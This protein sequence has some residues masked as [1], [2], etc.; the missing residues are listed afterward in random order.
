M[1]VIQKNFTFF[2]LAR[3]TFTYF[4]LSIQIQHLDKYR[5]LHCFDRPLLWFYTKFKTLYQ[6]ANT[7]IISA[8]F[9][10]SKVTNCQLILIS[11]VFPPRFHALST[12][13]S[14]IL[15]NIPILYKEIILHTQTQVI[16]RTR[17]PLH[18]NLMSTYSRSSYS[19]ASG[20]RFWSQW[21]EYFESIHQKDPLTDLWT[22]IIT[23]E[24]CE[25][26]LNEY[27]ES[28]TTILLLN[29]SLLKCVYKFIHIH[30]SS[31]SVLS[32]VWLADVFLCA[33]AVLPN[34]H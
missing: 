8:I 1:F 2:N 27:V 9:S 19:V 33:T 4:V 14:P 10:I 15:A 28:F 3:Y 5:L 34:P 24:P 26:I 29:H 22:Y 31:A 23:P 11:L 18:N 12:R 20:V 25:I 17:E 16:C 6:I 7:C 21:F 30:N 13:A 32:L